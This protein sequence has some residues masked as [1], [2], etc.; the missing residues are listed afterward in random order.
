MG[1]QDVGRA[2]PV[3]L[4]E[5]DVQAAA[6][7]DNFYNLEGPAVLGRSAEDPQQ[8]VLSVKE[9]VA[10]YQAAFERYVLA[11][12]D[13]IGPTSFGPALRAWVKVRRSEGMQVDPL[14]PENETPCD[15]MKKHYQAAY[16]SAVTSHAKADN[17]RKKG[18]R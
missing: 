8:L 1:R 3:V 15:P 5:V 14:Q 6:E 4:R 12:I 13:E 18:S 10:E 11:R 7:Q 9:R 16:D 2:G 17:R